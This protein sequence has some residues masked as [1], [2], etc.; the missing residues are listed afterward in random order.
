RRERSP[1]RSSADV[2]IV[3]PE[4]EMRLVPLAQ[5]FNV[6]STLSAPAPLTFSVPRP[7][8]A[9]SEPPT[10]KEEAEAAPA[11]RSKVPAAPAKAPTYAVEATLK[12]APL[13]A[14]R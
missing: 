8:A 9:D 6:P 7:P 14:N 10:K 12:E 4:S 13:A 2:L 1:P 11:E 3:P 5:T